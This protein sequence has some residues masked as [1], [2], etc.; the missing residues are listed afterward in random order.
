MEPPAS[1]FAPPREKPI[2]FCSPAPSPIS[3]DSVTPLTAIDAEVLSDDGKDDNGD[4]E[5][6]KA[7]SKPKKKQRKKGK[8]GKN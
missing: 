8:K 3:S 4:D 2:G 5:V 1:I 7:V 6:A